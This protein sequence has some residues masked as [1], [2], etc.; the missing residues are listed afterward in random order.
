MCKNKKAP[1]LNLLYINPFLNHFTPPK[2][3]FESKLLEKSL[4]SQNPQKR[5]NKAFYVNPINN[6]FLNLKFYANMSKSLDLKR[7]KIEQK[8]GSLYE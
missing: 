2:T 5:L 8:K 1:P 6:L 3:L 7:G 4:D